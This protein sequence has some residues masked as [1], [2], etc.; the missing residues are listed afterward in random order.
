MSEDNKTPDNVWY[1]LALKD[2]ALMI[3]MVDQL[4]AIR[5][6]LVFIDWIASILFVA[7]VIGLIAHVFDK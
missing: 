2:H 4:D 1:V 6:E 5:K 7:Y 3:K